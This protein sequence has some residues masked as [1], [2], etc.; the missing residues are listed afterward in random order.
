MRLCIKTFGDR[1]CSTVDA[2]YDV[3]SIDIACANYCLHGSVFT[4]NCGDSLAYHNGRMFA[5]K[6]RDNDPAGY[7]CAVAFKGAFWH[8]PC[9]YANPTGTYYNRT[10]L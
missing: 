6:D 8:N 4:G 7:N 2:Y 1:Q 10:K 9:H 3:C 5:T